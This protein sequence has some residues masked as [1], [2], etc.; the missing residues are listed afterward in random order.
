M[1][2]IRIALA[3]MQAQSADVTGNLT[4]IERFARDAATRGADLICYPE[5]CLQGYS[6]S[7]QGLKPLQIPGPAVERI[8]A[9][10]QTYGL[11]M[12][13][14]MVE[15]S[16]KG[17]PYITH[18]IAYPH[19]NWDLYRKTHLGVHEKSCF[20]P[21][22]ELPVFHYKKTTFGLL[23]CW[24]L[25]FPETA[26]LLAL[27]GAEI[28][29]APHASPV[30]GADRR[31]I[32]LKYL[33][34]RAYDNTVFLACCNQV[35][36]DGTGRIFGGGAMVI[37]P[38]GNVLTEAFYQGDHLLVADLQPELLNAIRAGRHAAMRHRFYLQA[39]RPELYTGLVCSKKLN[40]AAPSTEVQRKAA[41]PHAQAKNHC[42]KNNVKT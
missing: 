11:A 34:A 24:D 35:G 37:D 15:Y 25:H 41:G 17:K 4:K 36:N 27:K 39:R 26:A 40:Q 32:W 13:V 38:R 21:G 3:Q 2:S 42:C 28:I 23:I 12:L 10:A 18:L 9:L 7:S 1:N 33:P 5:L 16:P 6:C 30:A 20:A 14:G 29:F 22:Q 19:G 8:V 31:R